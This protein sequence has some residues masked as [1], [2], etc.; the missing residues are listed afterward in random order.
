MAWLNGLSAGEADPGALL[1]LHIRY[2]VKAVTLIPDRNWRAADAAKGAALV[3]ELGRFVAACR[4][5]RLPLLAGTEMNAPGQLLAD[6]FSVE[7]LAPFYDDFA[8]G[9]ETM[10]R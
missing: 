7:A 9:V 10:T 3:A 1:D 4:E 8:A 2:G 5:R 6:D